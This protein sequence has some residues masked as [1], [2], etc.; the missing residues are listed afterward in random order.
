VDIYLHVMKDAYMRKVSNQEIAM[1]CYDVIIVTAQCHGDVDFDLLQQAIELE[2]GRHPLVNSHLEF[3]DGEFYFIRDDN[4]V[5]AIDVKTG[6]FNQVRD[7]CYNMMLD[8]EREL[9]RVVI[10][11]Q[12]DRFDIHLCFSHVIADARSMI[13]CLKNC[14]IIY[15]ELAQGNAVTLDELD[16]MP[17]LSELSYQQVPTLNPFDLR[18]LQKNFVDVVRLTPTDASIKKQSQAQT[19][20]LLLEFTA[21]QLTQLLGQAREHNTT[22]NGVICAAQLFA[23]KQLEHADENKNYCL[24]KAVDSRDSL[25]QHLSYEH[26]MMGVCG[27][28]SFHKIKGCHDDI[29]WDLARQITDDA[30]A[31]AATQ[32]N[33]SRVQSYDIIPVTE[34]YD[35]QLEEMPWIKLPNSAVVTNVG[36]ADIGSEYGAILVD[37]LY[38]MTSQLV[39]YFILTVTTL[40]NILRINIG[41]TYPRYSDEQIQEFKDFFL[42]YLSI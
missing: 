32:T 41:Y 15:T 29:F 40:N 1:V 17:S 2:C 22:L 23:V 24:V 6:D 8:L 21:E 36:R 11:K 16:L 4:K 14:L 20:S 39:G 3:R 19:R 38:F 34:F 18:A 27:E 7:S 13:E 31:Y 28:I 37:K 35:P 5:V 26:V 9:A 30:K 12:G 42:Q 10:V 25:P 33:L